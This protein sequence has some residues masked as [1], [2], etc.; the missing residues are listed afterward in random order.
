[1]HISQQNTLF[2]L[3]KVSKLANNVLKGNRVVTFGLC[4]SML[5]SPL[6]API[7]GKLNS[8]LI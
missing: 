4:K 7:R 6:L 1:M 5:T 3:K 8:E 2:G